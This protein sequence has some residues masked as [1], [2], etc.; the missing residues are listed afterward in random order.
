VS[1]ITKWLATNDSFET[2]PAAFGC[3]VLLDGLGSVLG[4][5]GCEATVLSQERTQNELVKANN[6]L[7]NL[8]HNLCFQ[9]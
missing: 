7:K 1:A 6:G 8:S 2:Q 5:T 9:Y 4:A 3:T